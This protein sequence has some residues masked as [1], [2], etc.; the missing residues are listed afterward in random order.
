M[1]CSAADSSFWSARRS[2]GSAD[3]CSAISQQLFQLLMGTKGSL[4]R[5]LLLSQ[6]AAMGSR[7]ERWAPPAPLLPSSRARGGL[8]S[9]GCVLLAP[10]ARQLLTSLRKAGLRCPCCSSARSKEPVPRKK[11]ERA[12][13][14]ADHLLPLPPP[15]LL[16]WSAS[17]WPP[18]LCPPLVSRRGLAQGPALAPPAPSLAFAAPGNLHSGCKMM[19]SPLPVVAA[20]PRSWGC[21]GGS[22]AP[23]SMSWRV[24][25]SETKVLGAR[26]A[27]PCLKSDC[28]WAKPCSSPTAETTTNNLRPQLVRDL[29]IPTSGCR[30]AWDSD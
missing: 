17:C 7:C 11:W 15:P 4:L 14:P 27:D 13:A 20:L 10:G 23:D 28:D 29:L 12:C 30:R 1:C 18:S 5:G 16:L 25:R 2:A 21:A 3:I 9:C 26:E 22:A 19:P 6:P 8:R 24:V